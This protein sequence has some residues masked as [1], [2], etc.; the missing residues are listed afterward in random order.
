MSWTQIHSPLP[1]EQDAFNLRLSVC[2]WVQIL[3]S[4]Y[5][6]KGTPTGSLSIAYQCPLLRAF[7]RDQ[8]T[9]GHSPLNSLSPK[10]SSLNWRAVGNKI[11]PKPKWQHQVLN[12]AK[13]LDSREWFCP[14]LPLLPLLWYLD[15]AVGPFWTSVVPVFVRYQWRQKALPSADNW[16]LG[17]RLISVREISPSTAFYSLFG[18]F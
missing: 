2:P 3:Q 4:S 18:C 16:S 8:N 13:A 9:Y 10:S 15:E 5:S 12:R 6:L 11:C 17:I 1:C 14:G 7:Y